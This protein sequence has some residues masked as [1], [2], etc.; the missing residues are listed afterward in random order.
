MWRHR[1]VQNRNFL[2][3]LLLADY[4]VVSWC[5]KIVQKLVLKTL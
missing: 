3:L 4:Q 5:I 1:A 2:F